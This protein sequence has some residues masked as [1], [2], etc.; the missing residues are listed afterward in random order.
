MKKGVHNEWKWQSCMSFITPDRTGSEL[1]ANA[2]SS[3]L[4]ML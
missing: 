3:M 4:E 1:M 2:S